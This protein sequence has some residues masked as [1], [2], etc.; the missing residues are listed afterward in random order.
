[1]PHTV[2]VFVVPTAFFSTAPVK[3]IFWF[4][5]SRVPLTV[6][7]ML[8]AEPEEVAGPRAAERRRGI[9]RGVPTGACVALRNR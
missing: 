2:W 5:P 1:M 4:C 9:A 3:E 8:T 7:A 6:L